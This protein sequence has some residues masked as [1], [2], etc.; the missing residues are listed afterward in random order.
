MTGFMRYV[1]V[2]SLMYACISVS[3]NDTIDIAP[4]WNK[5]IVA[6]EKAIMRLMPLNTSSPG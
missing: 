2:L 1:T 5:L 6:G 4:G 3:A